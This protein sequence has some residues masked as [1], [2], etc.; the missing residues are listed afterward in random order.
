MMYIACYKDGVPTSIKA[1]DISSLS[2]GQED[3][4]IEYGNADSIKV[5]F[6][7]SKNIP[8]S[9]QVTL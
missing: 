3:Y 2:K 9:S 5:F 7:N 4:T 6:W 1:I 8:V